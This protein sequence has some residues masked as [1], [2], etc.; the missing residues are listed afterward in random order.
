MG[1][2]L[3]SYNGVCQLIDKYVN[4]YLIVK[5]RPIVR[6]CVMGFISVP[7]EEIMVKNMNKL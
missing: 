2:V 6:T 1:H 7:P 4:R 3:V 5:L